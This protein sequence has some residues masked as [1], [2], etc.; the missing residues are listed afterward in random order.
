MWYCGKEHGGERE[1]KR[2]W[3][4]RSKNFREGKIQS[5][6]KKFNSSRSSNIKNT[7]NS[8]RI[9]EGLGRVPRSGLFREP[10]VTPRE[11]KKVGVPLHQAR[12][13][14]APNEEWRKGIRR[15]LFVPP[16][17]QKFRKKGKTKSEGPSTCTWLTSAISPSR[18]VGKREKTH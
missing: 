10:H 15:R 13:D 1:P 11:E 12:E 3:R 16:I 8:G 17:N 18:L 2:E 9:V 4:E 6:K 5:T 14:K 7:K